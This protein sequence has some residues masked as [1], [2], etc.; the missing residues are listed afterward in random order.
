MCGFSGRNQL[1]VAL[2]AGLLRPPHTLNLPK[3]R[4]QITACTCRSQPVGMSAV[5]SRLLCAFVKLHLAAHMAPTSWL[6]AGYCDVHSAVTESRI[7]YS[8]ICH[9]KLNKP[10]RSAV[11]STETRFSLPPCCP[12]IGLACFFAYQRTAIRP[13]SSVALLQATVI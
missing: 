13:T 2:R 5:R 3:R 8:L 9:Q 10:S 1:G 4:R 12:F 7:L 6:S 11:R